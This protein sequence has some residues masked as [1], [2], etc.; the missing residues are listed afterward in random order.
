MKRTLPRRRTLALLLAAGFMAGPTLAQADRFP[1][2]PIKVLIGFTAGG[3]TDVPLRMPS[4]TEM[5]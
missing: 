1:N 4:D 3:S 2:R 5:S